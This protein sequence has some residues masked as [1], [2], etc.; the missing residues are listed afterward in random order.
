[1]VETLKLYGILV[2][3]QGLEDEISKLKTQM[4][5]LQPGSTEYEYDQLQL[6]RE[7]EELA[8]REQNPNLDPMTEDG[9]QALDRIADRDPKLQLIEFLIKALINAN[10]NEC[11]SWGIPMA[12]SQY[13]KTFE[14]T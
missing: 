8:I 7:E 13:T 6:A 12:D 14:V 9:S 4:Q 1:M 10:P 2:S 3:N 11:T 5:T